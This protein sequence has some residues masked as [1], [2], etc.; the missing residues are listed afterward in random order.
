MNEADLSPHSLGGLKSQMTSKSVT[1]RS[2]MDMVQPVSGMVLP[3]DVTQVPYWVTQYSVDEFNTLTDYRKKRFLTQNFYDMMVSKNE[4]DLGTVGA[5]HL[6]DLYKS[7]KYENKR[8]AKL[9]E[10]RRKRAQN[11]GDGLKDELDL[12]GRLD[13]A[14]NELHDVKRHRDELEAQLK[15]LN[16]ALKDSNLRAEVAETTAQE[17]DSMSEI[18]REQAAIDRE[19]FVEEKKEIDTLRQKLERTLAISRRRKKNLNV[20]RG[21]TV[22]DFRSIGNSEMYA[23]W[24]EKQD[25]LPET[26][27][28]R[29][30]LF[31]K[32]Y[33]E[34][35]PKNLAKINEISPTQQEYIAT[36]NDFAKFRRDL[37]DSG[38]MLDTGELFRLFASH[39]EERGIDFPRNEVVVFE[40]ERKAVAHEIHSVSS[41]ALVWIATV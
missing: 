40:P 37:G 15:D 10:T 5:D 16:E 32:R 18:T 24:A 12:Q 1:L 7:Q 34:L 26:A 22:F 41:G 3:P 39:A 2:G 11:K 21:G 33:P 20:A 4:F 36:S 14:R 23:A 27:G 35:T 38:N 19:R 17:A 8:K 6:Y 25:D 28:E 9:H 31:E 30:K 29:M 13:H